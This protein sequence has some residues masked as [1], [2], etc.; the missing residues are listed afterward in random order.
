MRTLWDEGAE[1]RL[2]W[3]KHVTGGFLC[4]A[5]LADCSRAV[6]DDLRAG[7]I[8]HRRAGNPSRFRS[9]LRVVS[10]RACSNPPG[11][12]ECGDRSRFLAGL[13]H[14]FRC[15]RRTSRHSCYFVR[16]TSSSRFGLSANVNVAFRVPSERGSIIC[17]QTD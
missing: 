9:L 10:P 3:S 17:G 5:V 13:Y 8:P 6:R 15:Y 1:N 2:Y 12:R 14:R 16:L 11:H 7:R 4:P